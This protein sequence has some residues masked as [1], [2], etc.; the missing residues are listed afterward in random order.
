MG[1]LLYKW[2]GRI[3]A[4]VLGYAILLMFANSAANVV[5]R[6]LFDQSLYFTEELNEFLIVLVTF[7]GLAHATRHGRH[8][9]MTAFSD[10]LKPRP[11]KVLLMLISLVTA[12]AMFWLAWLSFG[13]VQTVAASGKV[14]PALRVPLYLTYIWV[15]LGFAATGA[16]YLLA[17]WAN[18]RRPGIWLSP[19]VE[20][21]H[22]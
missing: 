17:V 14:T 6:H 20:E 5:G 18:I 9:R 2:S 1:A 15:P 21:G 3:E 22:R 12:S 16:Q 11:R 4:G 8:I 10:I 13:Y 7:V 19:E